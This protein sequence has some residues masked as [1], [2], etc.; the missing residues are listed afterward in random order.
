MTRH[1]D[2]ICLLQ[3][4]DYARKALQLAVDRKR[5]DLDDDMALRYALTHL[6]C[7]T[8]EAASRV[9]PDVRAMHPEVPWN[10]AKGMRNRLIHG[11]DIVDL[12]IIWET[13]VNDLPELVRVL[14]PI[15]ETKG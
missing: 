5:S 8:G 1:K 4:L 9:P 10:L 13:V 11:Y 2:E 3:M 14:E 7:I 12:D 6:I 15:A